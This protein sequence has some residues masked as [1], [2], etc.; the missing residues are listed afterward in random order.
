VREGLGETV[1]VPSGAGEISEGKSEHQV[2]SLP[3]GRTLML[4]KLTYRPDAGLG[5][6]ARLLAGCP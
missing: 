2:V 3:Q 5:R 1:E 4:L 6:V